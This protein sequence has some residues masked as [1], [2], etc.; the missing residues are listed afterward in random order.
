M[1]L[2]PCPG[3]GGIR[4][5]G[6]GFPKPLGLLA[7]GSC[8]GDEMLLGKRGKELKED[9]GHIFFFLKILDRRWVM[10]RCHWKRRQRFRFSHAPCLL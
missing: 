10:A 5:A 9:V 4:A 3:K 2:S 8:V 7:R 1:F 6:H